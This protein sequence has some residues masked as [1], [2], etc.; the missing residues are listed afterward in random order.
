MRGGDAPRHGEEYAPYGLGLE[1][2]DGR[3]THGCRPGRER[4]ESRRPPQRREKRAEAFFPLRATTTVADS[5]CDARAAFKKAAEH[6][7][8]DIAAQFDA[9]HVVDA[10][11]LPGGRSESERA[12][13]AAPENLLNDRCTPGNASDRTS[14][15]W[16]GFGWDDTVAG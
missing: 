13:C 14:A 3:I 1:P 16:P 8:R 11:V 12:S 10:R 4:R 9:G 7:V 6:V 5:A 2:V 15:S